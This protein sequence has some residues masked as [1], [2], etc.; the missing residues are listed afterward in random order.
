MAEGGAHDL[1]DGVH[2]ARITYAWSHG[3]ALVAG[4]PRRLSGG[5]QAT[6]AIIAPT[7]MMTAARHVPMA[8]VFVM[9]A[10]VAESQAIA[11]ARRLGAVMPPP[12]YAS[13]SRNKIASLGAPSSS[14]VED[15]EFNAAET[16]A[17]ATPEADVGGISR[18]NKAGGRQSTSSRT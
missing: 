18:Q 16:A 10:S 12:T 11:T 5:G 6:Y 8:R 1:H 7:M 4:Q 17:E 9:G 14:A 3:R 2:A 15:D 13:H